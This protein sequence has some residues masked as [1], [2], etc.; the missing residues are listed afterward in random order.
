[1]PVSTD[2]TPAEID[3]CAGAEGVYGLGWVVCQYAET[4]MVSE[5]IG[6]VEERR[7]YFRAHGLRSQWTIQKIQYGQD[8]AIVAPPL[9][10][11]VVAYPPSYPERL[12]PAIAKKK[13]R[14]DGG[15][16]DRWG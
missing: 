9:P 5:T 1:M 10:N 2:E 3:Y 7:E 16:A 6:K 11:S 13:E 14:N 15:S 8:E 4:H 12:S